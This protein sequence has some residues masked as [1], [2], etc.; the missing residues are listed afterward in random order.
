MKAVYLSPLEFDTNILFLVTLPLEDVIAVICTGVSAS[1]THTISLFCPMMSVFSVLNLSVLRSG[2]SPKPM[3]FLVDG[4][5]ILPK[6]PLG[7]RT[8]G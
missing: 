5:K 7:W 2:C 1:A 3:D 8:H 6:P 4:K